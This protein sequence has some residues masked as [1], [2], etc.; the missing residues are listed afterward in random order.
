M[1]AHKPEK[2]KVKDKDPLSKHQ[3]TFEYKIIK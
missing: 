2:S 1:A 3:A